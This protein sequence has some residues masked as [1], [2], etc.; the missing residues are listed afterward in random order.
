MTMLPGG[1]ES[2]QELL[3]L[4]EESDP[5]DRETLHRLSETAGESHAELLRFLTQLDFTESDAL[6][7]W[8]AILEHR[9]ELSAKLSRPCSVQVAALDYFQNV[10]AEIRIPKILEMSTFLETERSAITDGL[11]GLYNRQF[12]DASLRRELKR[13]RRYGLAFSLV[14]IDLDDFK[15]VNDIYGHVVGDE[16]LRLTSNVIRASVREIDVACRYGG[17]EFAVILPETSRTGAYHRLRAHPCRREG[18]VRPS[19]R[20]IGSSHM[21][22]YHQRRHRHLSDGL[23]LR[24]RASCGWPTAPS[25][26]PSSDGKNKITLHAEEKRRSPRLD[27]RKVL[28]FRERRTSRVAGSLESETRNL[29]RNGALVESHIPL[30]IG[31]ELDIDIQPSPRTRRGS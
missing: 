26:A 9:D 18:D 2:R 21:V 28:I 20:R 31:T 1:S 24:R 27:A 3:K 14:M 8:R 25:T 17:E 7:H 15:S 11:T 6:D 19:A 22:L 10:K 29:S 12:F 23:E 4:L 5:T 13:A 16:A 30:N